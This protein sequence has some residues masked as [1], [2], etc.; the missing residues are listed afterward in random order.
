MSRGRKPDVTYWASRKAYGCWIDGTQHILAKGAKDETKGPTYLAALD[1]FEKLLALEADKGSDDYLVSAM[2]NQYRA[3]VK[4]RRSQ[5][6][7]IFDAMARGFSVGFGHLELCELQPFH[8]KGW[9]K[10]Q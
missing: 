5:M 2:L 3:H 4:D 7:N 9:L 6:P 10:E 8:L 1:H